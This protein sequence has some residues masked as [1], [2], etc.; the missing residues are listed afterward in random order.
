MTARIGSS[1][2]AASTRE[3]S[4]IHRQPSRMT[5][6]TISPRRSDFPSSHDARTD[7][8]ERKGEPMDAATAQGGKATAPTGKAPPQ[9]GNRHWLNLSGLDAAKAGLALYIVG[10]LTS[11]IYYARFHILALDFTRIQ[12]IVV[13]VYLILVYLAA[14][15]GIVWCVQWIG[16]QKA[17]RAL[18]GIA[19]LAGLD[20]G[21]AMLLGCAWFSLIAGTLTTLAL[22]VAL[23]VD[24]KTLWASLRHRTMELQLLH[25]PSRETLVALGIFVCLHF[26]LFWFPRIPGNFAGGKPVPVQVFTENTAL[27]D[28]RFV[29]RK[30]KPKING[31]LDSY[32]LW[33][34]FQ[35]DTDVYLLDSLP[36]DGTLIDND[37]MRI[38]KSQ[39]LRMDYN[40]SP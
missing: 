36:A 22:Q 6:V 34:L 12:S 33:L 10:M 28:S 15:A 38:T 7:C 2:A 16:G 30:N 35:T 11:G 8:G 13:G 31:Q 9:P 14:P 23:F 40:T 32:S 27:P 26:S 17:L 19:L 3:I 37:V 20:A 5:V 29:D 24:W 21:V 1:T 25:Q 4:C 39:V 18:V